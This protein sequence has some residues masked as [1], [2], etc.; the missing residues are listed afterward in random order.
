VD[1]VMPP[2]IF[3]FLIFRS[4]QRLHRRDMGERLG[5]GAMEAPAIDGVGICRSLHSRRLPCLSQERLPKS[6][7]SILPD[8]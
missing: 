7:R 3:L 2:A 1:P 4:P 6:L 8:Y 5:E